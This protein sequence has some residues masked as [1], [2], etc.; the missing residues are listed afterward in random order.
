[1]IL[2]RRT[3]AWIGRGKRGFFSFLFLTNHLAEFLGLVFRRPADPTMFSHH[4]TLP[5]PLSSPWQ[6]GI[7][8]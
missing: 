1:M 8:V 6:G 3:L 4:D 7:Y 5:R 2:R